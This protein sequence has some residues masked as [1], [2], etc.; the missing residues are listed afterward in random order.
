MNWSKFKNFPVHQEK[1]FTK[2]KEFAFEKFFKKAAQDRAT[3]GL[4][5]VG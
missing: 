1:D 3:L 5:S 2:M 4:L